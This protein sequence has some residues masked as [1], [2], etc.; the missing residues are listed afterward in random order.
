MSLKTVIFVNGQ[1]FR[2]NL[3]DFKFQ[4]DPPH[5]HHNEYRLD[6]KHFKWESFFKDSLK[7]FDDVVGE[8][9]ELVRV[10]WY[11]A[12]N[13]TSWSVNNYRANQI[14]ER[15]ADQFP[16]LTTEMIVS[17]ARDWHEQ[18]TRRFR[19]LR[20]SVFE[21]IQRNS[22]MLEFRYVGNYVLAP[23][24]PHR[25]YYNNEGDLQYQGTQIGEKGVDVGIAVDMISKMNNYDSAVLISGDNDFVSV[26]QYL[27]DNLKH[28][29]HFSVGHGVGHNTKFFSPSMK[30]IVDCYQGFDELELLENYIDE[31]S[32]IPSVILDVI[33]TK[34]EDLRYMKDNQHMIGNVIDSD[35]EFFAEGIE[36]SDDEYE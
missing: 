20:K 5:P 21:E 30:N 23:F 32:N 35:N 18:E 27:K 4:S 15:Y 2:H 29:Y 33:Y 8:K 16:E 25:V 34:I 9:H 22:N 13:I 7:K 31:N 3:R 1:N 17:K 14:V 24:T 11:Y 12:K 36:N 28:V 19:Q 26:I 6:E 10:Y